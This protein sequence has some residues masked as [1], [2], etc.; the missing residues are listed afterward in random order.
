MA[1]TITHKKN[2]TAGSTPTT[3]QLTDGEIA[4]N[5]NDGR[6]FFRR[7]VSGVYSIR[8]LATLDGTQTFTNKTLT[9]P[10]MSAPTVTGGMGVTGD[11][12]LTNGSVIIG[13][14]GTYAPGSIFSDANWGMLFRARTYVV[15]S[16]NQFPLKWSFRFPGLRWIDP[17]H[18]GHLG[19]L[20][21]GRG[22]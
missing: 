13:E 18:N 9:S 11:V 20:G 17:S 4:I 15:P 7:N 21:L 8:E 10:V 2:G 1:N 6:M 14:N 22:H 16:Q 5:Y 3:G 12:T 19:W